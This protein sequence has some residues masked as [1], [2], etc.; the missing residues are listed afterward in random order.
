M[1]GTN[2]QKGLRAFGCAMT[3]PA[4]AC[5]WLVYLRKTAIDLRLPWLA[6]PAIR[7]LRQVLSPNDA[8]LEWGAGGSTLFFLDLGCRVYTIESS[9]EWVSRVGGAI[10]KD[11]RRRWPPMLMPDTAD[12]VSGRTRV[13]RVDLILVDGLSE[14]RVDCVREC[15]HLDLPR[16]FVLDDSW[17]VEYHEISEMLSGFQRLKMR[18]FGP[19]RLGVTQTDIYRQIV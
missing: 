18:G 6:W 16:H 2:L 13:S 14:S 8:V 11:M 17:R 19:G 4:D 5:R 7:F 12:Y 9:E 10:S 15:L 3:H 1:Y